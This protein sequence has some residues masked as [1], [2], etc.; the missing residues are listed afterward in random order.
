VPAA[1]SWRDGG[2]PKPKGVGP[3]MKE[4]DPW[5]PGPREDEK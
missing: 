4:D 5:F 2:S 1:E 3:R